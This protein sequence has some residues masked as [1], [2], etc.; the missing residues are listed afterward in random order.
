MNVKSMPSVKIPISP[1]PA[2]VTV[3]LLRVR[4]DA[5]LDEHEFEQ[6]NGSINLPGKNT[7][8]I[9]KHA[10][11]RRQI[12]F[13]GS[14]A[15]LSGSLGLHDIRGTPQH[16]SS[17]QAEETGLDLHYDVQ[18]RIGIPRAELTEGGWDELLQLSRPVVAGLEL[19]TELWCRVNE[20]GQT[21]AVS[22]PISLEGAG[23]AGFNEITGVQ[24]VNRS[25]ADDAKELY[26]AIVQRVNDILGVQVTLEIGDSLDD[27]VLDAALQKALTVLKL[28]VPSV[29]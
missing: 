21:L 10:R 29:Q 19:T 3:D 26:S 5:I 4:L 13:G 7:E 2:S 12:N 9:G 23:V 11:F 28:A 16:I 8:T 27:D 20:S 14:P 15:E 6:I 25:S 24:L 18:I 22:L 1:I 17:D